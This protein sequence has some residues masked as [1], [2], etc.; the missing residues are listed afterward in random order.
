MLCWYQNLYFN[1]ITPLIK[2]SSTC[3][4]GLPRGADSDVVPDVQSIFIGRWGARRWYPLEEVEVVLRFNRT[5]ID[6]NN[7]LIH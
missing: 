1:P 7:L 3:E 4:P 6:R 2:L 5:N